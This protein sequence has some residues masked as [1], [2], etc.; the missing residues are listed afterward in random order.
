MATK[1]RKKVEKKAP[2]AGAG[3]RR[4]RRAAASKK[5]NGERVEFHVS[6]EDRETIQVAS[7]KIADLQVSLGAL[8][9]T[10]E[11]RKVAL[12]NAIG[13]ERGKFEALVKTVGEKGGANIGE[14]PWNY[15][16]DQGVFTPLQPQA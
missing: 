12:L 15:D 10:F 2:V 6:D 1:T 11:R 8:V 4:Q 13:Q 16:Q 7:D 5:A 14:E 3:N 9:E